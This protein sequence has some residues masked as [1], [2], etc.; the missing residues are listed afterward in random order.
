M[1]TLFNFFNPGRV[2]SRITGGISIRVFALLWLLM[3]QQNGLSGQIRLEKD[4][5]R[6]VFSDK[7]E[8]PLKLA[9]DAL[10]DDLTSIMGIC[11][12]CGRYITQGDF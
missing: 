7:E 1:P 2:M 8:D 6:I 3:F 4:K 10:Q 11:A 5:V 9:L 12:A